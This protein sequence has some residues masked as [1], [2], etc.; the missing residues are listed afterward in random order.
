MKELQGDVADRFNQQKSAAPQTF[1][2]VSEEPQGTK[3][4]RLLR[5][6]FGAFTIGAVA[7]FSK[8]RDVLYKVPY[9]PDVFLY[10]SYP[11]PGLEP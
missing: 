4:C 9:G 1:D 8:Q 11:C 10:G 3:A 7:F 5:L 2:H 6:A